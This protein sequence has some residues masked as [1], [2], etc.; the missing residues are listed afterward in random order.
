MLGAEEISRA[1]T[2]GRFLGVGVG[3]PVAEVEERLGDNVR[4]LHG[5][6]SARFLRLDFGLVEVT[7]TG[8]PEWVCQ[9]L[10]VQTHRL[11]EVPSLSRE[12]A[13]E[14]GLEF[15]ET[16]TWGELSP[17]A[18]ENS[19]LLDVS[20]YAVRYRFPAVKATVHLSENEKGDA[21]GRVIEKIS[22]G[23]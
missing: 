5:R 12:C 3:S 23:V 20:P 21:L 13:D 18:R 16:V 17:E 10:S 15:S 4:Q 8:E 14:F 1:L 11:A 2:T 6:A 9:W 7:F 22:I 19:V